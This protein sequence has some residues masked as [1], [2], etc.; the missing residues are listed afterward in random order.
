[1]TTLNHI[2][3]SLSYL[4]IVSMKALFGPETAVYCRSEPGMMQRA[5]KESKREVRARAC[6]PKIRARHDAEGGV[7]VREGSEGVLGRGLLPVFHVYIVTPGL[8][9]TG[10]QEAGG[11]KIGVEGRG[12]RAGG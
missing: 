6:L 3:I 1:M 4:E 7:G 12:L 8:G 9:R 11:G 5:V 2:L 10:W